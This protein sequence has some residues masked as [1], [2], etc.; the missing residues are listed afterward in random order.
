MNTDDQ[1]ITG[2][3]QAAFTD[4]VDP[5]NV[6]AD[7]R[8]RELNTNDDPSYQALTNLICDYLAEVCPWPASLLDAGCGLGFLTATLADIGYDATGL[9]P[10][11]RVV[12]LGQKRF[13]DPRRL[14]ATTMESFA[15][16]HNQEFDIVVANMTLHCVPK[17]ASFLDAVTEVLKPGGMLVATIPDPDTYLQGRT[18]I[19]VS[20]LDLRQ[21]QDLEIPFRIH[22]HAPHPARVPY[23]H[24]PYRTYIN[25]ARA[26]GLQVANFLLPERLGV[27]RSRDVSLIEF[28]KAVADD[29]E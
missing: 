9:D 3:D 1:P 29:I 18:D 16:C 26:A 8:F 14:H 12:A 22:G 2:A 19:D 25:A 4:D 20:D 28:K 5:W 15:R 23:F 11:A 6:N 10:A 27:G 17:L 24:H 21:D 7:E 13:E